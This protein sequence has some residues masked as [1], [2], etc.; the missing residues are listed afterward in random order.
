MKYTN[1]LSALLLSASLMFLPLSSFAEEITFMLPGDVPMIMEKI[2]AGTFM[3]G[4]INERGNEFKNE[5]QHQV[6]LTQ[7][8]YI[9]KTE[10]TQKQWQAVTGTPM[11]TTGSNNCGNG[12]IG[13][14]YPVYCVS[15][16][17]IQGPG[18]FM[19]KL[20]VL[21]GESGFRLPTEAQW[22][23]AARAD[24]TTRFWYGDVLS[25]DDDCGA[26]ATH[27]ENM[28]YCGNSSTGR[29]SV[30]GSKAPNPYGLYDMNGN[31]AEIVFDRY[32]D[33][34]GSATGQPV[35]DPTG[36]TGNG[37]IVV[38][39][40]NA[41]SEVWLARNA[42]RLGAS[43]GDNTN[44]D[45]GRADWASFR[46]AANGIL[47][48][49]FQMNAGLNDAWYNPVTSGQ[50]FFITVFPELN[51]V[52]LAWFT[53]DT[54]LP[55]NESAANL[56]SPGHRWMTAI[57]TINGNTS[58]MNIEFTSGGL[59]DEASEITSTDPP[60]SDGTITLTFADCSSGTI[61]YDIPSISRT[62]TVPIQRVANDNIELCEAL[63]TP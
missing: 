21:L 39:G 4:S 51:V 16:N 29:A 42:M 54:E 45:Q 19:E 2:P 1:T 20:N 53:Y 49:P 41:G 50:G 23:R 38:K 9:G 10:V 13:D 47:N 58:I 32:S 61:E 62:G 30:V 40:G 57:G 5:P 26:C 35:T 34:Y 17:Q 55:A 56:G 48:L 33:N 44:N 43:P 24:T 8:Y 37:D 3:M 63:S 14:E 59:F 25:C 27:D 31:L 22:E 12:N 15:W 7:D 18:G 46:V 11:S 52:S 36:G 28:N 6:T 60:G